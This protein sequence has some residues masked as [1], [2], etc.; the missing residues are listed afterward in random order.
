MSP[1]A[2]R[3]NAVVRA[4]GRVI[5]SKQMRAMVR[6]TLE[7]RESRADEAKKP[8]TDSSRAGALPRVA[9]NADAAWRCERNVA[10][11]RA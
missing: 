8:G 7:E 3:T 9:R 4:R 5:L 1:R 10:G 2:S 6:G 11:D